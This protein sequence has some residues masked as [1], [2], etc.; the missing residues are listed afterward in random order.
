ML[1]C[2]YVALLRIDLSEREY[3]GEEL[4]LAVKSKVSNNFC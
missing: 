1:L 2:C 3:S 4:Y